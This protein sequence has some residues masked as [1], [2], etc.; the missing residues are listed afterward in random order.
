MNPGEFAAEPLGNRRERRIE[1][2]IPGDPVGRGGSLDAPHDEEGLAEDRRIIAREQRL[3]N[4]YPGPEGGLQHCEFL[5][6]VE[7]RGHSCRG[8]GAQDQPLVAGE[9]ASGEMRVDRPIF[10]NGAAPQRREPGNLDGT[11]PA[12]GSEEPCQARAALHLRFRLRRR[13]VRHRLRELHRLHKRSPARQGTTAHRR[14]PRSARGAS[15]ECVRSA[16]CRS[17]SGRRL[18]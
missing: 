11:R 9:H 12:G 18:G 4:R 10:L 17:R 8:G 1:Y 2:R 6:S 15:A 3:G 13:R 16:P 5:Q 14:D 7:A